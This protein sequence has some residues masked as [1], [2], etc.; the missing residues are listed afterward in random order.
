MDLKEFC[1]P[2]TI[3]KEERLVVEEG[4]DLRLFTFFPAEKTTRPP[5]LFIP[6][7]ISQINGWKDVL[8]EMTRNYPVYYLETREKSSAL[9]DGDQDQGIISYAQDLINAVDL[10]DLPRHNY[11][12]FGSS[13]GGTAILDAEP[14]LQNK[15]AA[16]ILIGPNAEFRTPGWGVVL[17]HLIY[18]GLFF[19]FKSLVKQYL[20]WF[21]L[22][23]DT[24]RAQYE[25]YCRALDMAEPFRLKKAALA[26]KDYK[27]WE[28]LPEIKTPALIIGGNEDKLHEPEN[29]IKIADILENGELLD[30]Q[31]NT[32][33]HSALM[34]QKMS[35]F[36]AGIS[37]SLGKALEDE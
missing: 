1:A 2:G 37:A 5:V 8:V 29:L 4:V 21:R 16:L 11:I 28:I 36:I 35:R 10:L 14:K 15:P 34:V 32:N 17:I 3:I 24:D 7:W 20:K 33:T 26:L 18:P 13:L 27:V 19:I 25:K 22:N 12:L 31:T 6:G 9:L 30:M 23:T